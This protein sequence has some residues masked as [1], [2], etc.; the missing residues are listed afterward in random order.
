MTNFVQEGKVLHYV[1]KEGDNIKSGD[2]VA[3]ENVVGVAVTDGKVGELLAVSVDGVYDVPVPVAAGRILQGKPVYYDK[4]AKEITLDAED[5]VLV[6]YAWENG[7]P[8]G[9]VPVNLLF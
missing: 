6:G 1:P 9:T 4:T 3:V 8:G 5:N 2:L 7:E